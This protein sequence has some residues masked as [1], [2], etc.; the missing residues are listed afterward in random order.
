[1]TVAQPHDLVC[2]ES[3]TVKN[4]ILLL[5]F[6]LK[7]VNVDSHIKRIY[8]AIGLRVRAEFQLFME[9]RRAVCTQL[10]IAFRGRMLKSAAGN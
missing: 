9:W 8:K 2:F 7:L 10:L 5:R 1:M 3:T 4:R 6:T